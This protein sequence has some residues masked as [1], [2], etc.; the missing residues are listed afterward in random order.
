MK[1]ALLLL[2]IT[3]LYS[4]TSN[5]QNSLKNAWESLFRN[6]TES[7]KKIFKELELQPETSEEA[8]LSL[9]LLAELEQSNSEASAYFRKFYLQSK[10][11]EPYILALW[12]SPSVNA[13]FGKQSPSSLAFISQISKTAGFGGSLHAMANS[14]IGTHFHTLRK[15]AEADKAYLQLGTIDN[16]QITGTFENISTSGYDNYYDVLDKP[17]ADAVFTGKKNIEFRWRKVPYQRRDKW[18]DFTYYDTPY[19]SIVFAQT[20]LNSPA[21]LEAQLRVGVSGSVKVWVNDQLLIAEAE[22]RNNDLDTYISTLKLHKGYNRILVQIGE[23][24]AGRSNFMLRITDEKGYPV[25]GLTS[26]NEYRDYEKEVGFVPE[27]ITPKVYTYFRQLLEQDSTNYLNQLLLAKLYLSDDII[28]DARNILEGL[29]SKFPQ[30]TYINTLMITL[31]S[32]ENNRT[33]VE[34]LQENIKSADPESTY[35]L[36]LLYDDYIN[37]EDYVKAEAVV[38]RLEERLGE[39][40]KTMAK[41]IALAGKQ[42]NQSRV[43]ELVEKA[44]KN[45]PDNRN[46]AYVKYLLEKDVKK[47][48]QYLNILKKYWSENRDYD[49][50]KFLAGAYF[51]KGD[52]KSGVDVY[53]QEIK[54]EPSG[55][56]IYKDLAD[57]YFTLQKYDKA[58]EYLLKA[59]EIAPNQSSYYMSLGLVFEA[60]KQ[61]DKA[62]E[63]YK[64]CL[65]LEPNNYDAIQQ[66]RRLKKSKDVF[67]YFRQP[68]VNELIKNA[69]S[70][71]DY[72]DDHSVILDE[73]VQTVVYENGGSEEKHFYITKVLT[74]KGLEDLKEFGIPYNNDQSLSVEVAETIK[75]N[76]T[77][78]PAEQNYNNLVFTNL[79]VGD[80][81]NIRYRLR[82]YNSGSLAPHFWSSFYFSHGN[83]YVKSKYSLLIDKTKKFDYKFSEKNVEPKKQDAGEFDL[84]VWEAGNQAALRYEDKMPPMNDVANI[85]YLSTIP[86]WKFVATW[87][88]NIA[89]AKARSS[90]EVKTCVN[91]LFRDKQKLTELE[92]VRKI[93][94][95]ITQ[96]IAYS[97]VSF[98]QSGIVPQ[99]PSTVLNTRIGDCKDVSTLFLAMCKEIGVEAE[100]VLVKTRE[101]GQN[102]LLLPSIDFNHCIAKVNVGNKVHFL[103]LTSS[104]LPFASFYNQTLSSTIL[105][106]NKNTNNLSKLLPSS[107]VV[108][109][110]NYVTNIVIEGNDMGINETN[111]CTGASASMYR[112]SFKDL[113]N[114]DQLKK[115]KEQISYKYPDNEAI[116]LDFINLDPKYAASDTLKAS[117]SY[118]LLKVCKPVAGMHIFSLPWSTALD[119]SSFSMVE[120]RSFGIDLTQIFW[121]DL[122][123]E[124]LNLT[125]PANKKLVE[126]LKSLSIDN[127]YFTY[128][129]ASSG[130]E[131]KIV[132]TRELVFKKDYVSKEKVAEF[133]KLLKQVIESDHQ[134]LA[135]K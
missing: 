55:V 14:A 77:K 103:E 135:I 63:A 33:G 133:N 120:P 32:K 88:N 89:T 11:P 111:F 50:A 66:L 44:Y 92:K 107:R 98:R 74:Q 122:N 27:R 67:E 6:E 104:S 70:L 21:A 90:Y 29:K 100:L 108:N 53:L 36:E 45:W 73:E 115:M 95:Y 127:E 97:S 7:A 10:N 57:N 2:S 40:E 113:S 129:L 80:V 109:Q 123:K 56:G 51:S 49:Y 18:F 117:S 114:K 116:A 58:E 72:P 48:T 61:T 43:I 124:Q 99:N 110:I 16:W 119:P 60:I 126:P 1:K 134:Q 93:Y 46:F 69:P 35:A 47:S 128:K 91:E 39:S 65:A 22:E 52:V 25:P 42:N 62:E 59:I 118:K 121:N 86:D 30:S 131:N 37:Q 87:Y 17:K 23:S 83:P 9:S 12:R 84:Y 79:E 38:A 15:S 19:N 132:I 94:H 20:F 54:Q 76:G 13:S 3:L 106:I 71:K 78:T 75:P 125:L 5:A 96:N 4:F 8:L 85:L 101:S 28:F 112:D 26:V 24:Y 64:K 130:K 105:E 68:D 82:N 81:I 34:T 41:K 102:T 31:H